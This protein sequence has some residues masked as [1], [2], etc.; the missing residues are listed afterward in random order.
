MKKYI[1]PKIKAIAL[2]NEQAVLQVCSVSGVMFTTMV[3]TV[4]LCAT[5]LGPPVFTCNMTAKGGTGGG[6]G[7]FSAGDYETGSLAS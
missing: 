2:D 5:T 7:R 1:E 3:G 4:Y 6:G